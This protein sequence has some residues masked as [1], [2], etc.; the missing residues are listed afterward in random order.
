[1]GSSSSTLASKCSRFLPP[2]PLWPLLPPMA[3][4]PTVPPQLTTLPLLTSQLRSCPLSHTPTSMVSLMT[5]LRLTSRRP[6]PRMLKARLLDLSP[7]LFPTA[8]SRPPPTPPTTTTDS[9]LRSPTR[10][11][12]STPQSP[13]VDTDP[14][15]LPT[16]PPVV[17][18]TKIRTK[19]PFGQGWCV[20]HPS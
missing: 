10:E 16:S 15:P 4:Q 1:M 14:P 18:L 11:P 17:K 3:P 13:Q 7:S 12:Q 9:S 6:R 20:R 2:L 8:V 5:T 19:T